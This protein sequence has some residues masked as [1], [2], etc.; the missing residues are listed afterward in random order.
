MSNIEYMIGNYHLGS[1]SKMKYKL[2]FVNECKKYR[3]DFWYKDELKSL[4]IK[5]D[6]LDVYQKKIAPVK[7]NR[8]SSYEVFSCLEK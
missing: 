1:H 4:M 3:Y 5:H 6:M 8:W 7:N 2:A